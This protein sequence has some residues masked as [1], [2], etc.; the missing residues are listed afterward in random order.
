LIQKVEVDSAPD[1]LYLVS[2]PI[3]MKLFLLT[4][5]AS[6]CAL[7]A[8]G[9]SAPVGQ[10]A[11]TEWQFGKNGALSI[12]YDDGSYNQFKDALPIMEK[13]QLPATFF[14]ITGGIPGSK[15]HGKFIGR[16]VKDIIAET[17][18]TPTNDQNFL[19]RCSAAGYLG[20]K[21]TI[22][23]VT[24]AAGMYDNPR[25]K[26][27]AYKWMDSLYRKVRNGDFEPGYQPCDEYLQEKGSTWDDFRRDA[28]LGYEFASHSITH[29][30][31]PGLDSVNIAYELEKSKEEMRDQMG[32]Q[33]TFST[34]VPYG[35]ENERVMKI[36]YKIYPALRNRMPEPWLTELDR[37][38]KKTPAVNDKDYVQWQRECNTHAP[39]PLMKSWV[40]T[41]VARKDTWLVLVIH[42][43]DHLGYEA[44]SDTLLNEYFNYI[45]DRQKDLWIATFG[46]V[47]K[48]MREREAATVQ[49]NAAGSKISVELNHS[50]DKSMYY[51]P[52]TLK[53]Y[54][55]NGWKKVT[56]R[57]GKHIEHADVMQ[58][59][60]GSYVIYKADPG[61]E[62]ITLSG[63]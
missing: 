32:E 21:G 50:L 29:A 43:V 13:L 23:Y 6:C 11:V 26:A 12:T 60:K 28:K 22:T 39:L 31:M 3:M 48:Y 17:A 1:Q 41:A 46:D 14:I 61:K 47:T 42:G 2:I 63:G 10:T 49:S 37:P 9:Q 56:I 45:K 15:Y 51:I 62:R 44:L 58:D 25:R 16:P 30:S 20:Y 7:F 5:A 57:Q 18:T 54:V 55:S 53:T 36:A 19:E 8:F 40:D 4:I 59:D 38:S 52:L 34:E 33:Y 24:K 27:L 35:Y